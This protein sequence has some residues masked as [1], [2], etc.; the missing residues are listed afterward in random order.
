[1]RSLRAFIRTRGVASSLAVVLLGYTPEE[2][3]QAPTL[4]ELHALAPRQV[5][6]QSFALAFEQDVQVEAVGA[7]GSKHKTKTN[8]LS[9]MF[10]RN[11]TTEVQPWSGNAWILDLSSRRVVWA[12]NAAATTSGSD[13]TREFKGVV[14][15]PKGSYSAYYAAFPDGEYWTDDGSKSK[16]KGKWHAFDDEPLDRFSLR[17]RADGR[18]LGIGEVVKLREISAGSTIVALQ[19]TACE[20]FQQSGFALS[21]PTAIDI[22]V[23]GEARDDGEFDYGWII[24]A[25][26]RATVWK[27]SWGDSEPA[28]GAAKNR[29]TRVSRVLPA[30]RYAAFYATDDSHDPSQWNA[31]PPH[32]PDAWGLRITVKDAGDL[33]AVK[34]FNYEHVPAASTIVA[35]TGIGDS[36]SRKQGFTLTRPMDV[37][38]YALGEGR[39]GRMYDY[40]WITAGGSRTRV[41]EMNYGNSQAAGGDRKNRLVDSTVHLQKGSYV[42]HYLSDDSHSSAEWNAAAPPDGRRWGITLLAANGP[43][44]RSAIAPYEEKADPSILAQAVGVRDDDRV[45]KRFSLE[46]AGDVKVYALGEASGREMADY[47]WIED[48]RDGRR[49]WEM[50]YKSTE[51]AGGASKNRRFEGTVHLPPGEYILGYETDGS[52]AFGDWNADPPDDPEG[53]GITVYKTK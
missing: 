48:A 29:M 42:L 6:S 34:P 35:L 41:W 36:D 46:R 9:G 26:T 11:A 25:D 49:V 30:G 50:T 14:R 23:E 45:R 3:S 19:A 40:G 22:S 44:D 2:V 7:E 38:I 43:L 18:Q 8:W 15:L 53:W 51:H 17:L 16:T 28:G 20:Q 5:Q 10:Q 24:D 47:G 1:M 32:D 39:D 21:K 37:R 4:V 13:G 31:Q 52:H 33:S 27:F 12:L